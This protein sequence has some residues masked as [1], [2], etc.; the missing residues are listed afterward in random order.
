M[1]SAVESR[2]IEGS[3]DESPPHHC[4]EMAQDRKAE[5]RILPNI[6]IAQVG[7]REQVTI[8]TS[9]TSH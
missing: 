7:Y 6:G 8:S 9:V 4:R 1:E 3:L 5:G 2:T